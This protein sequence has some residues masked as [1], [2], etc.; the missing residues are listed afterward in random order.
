MGQPIPFRRRRPALP[1]QW[2]RYVR[3]RA[4]TAEQIRLTIWSGLLRGLLLFQAMRFWPAP[5]RAADPPFV[6]AVDPYAEA[7]RS[8]AILE[9][10]EAAPPP[11]APAAEGGSG[12]SAAAGGFVRVID[13]DTFD[14]GGVRIRIADIDTPEVHGRCPPKRHSPPEPPPEPASSSP[15]EPSSST[16]SPAAATRTVTDGSFGSSRSVGARWGTSWWRRGWPVPGRGGG[17]G[18]ASHPPGKYIM[19]LSSKPCLTISVARNGYLL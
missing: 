18:G 17:R 2:A 15:P 19:I 10:Q 11:L 8:K 5:N 14:H 3:P 9:A 12:P 6:T 16:H 1:A 13:G 7:K 4:F